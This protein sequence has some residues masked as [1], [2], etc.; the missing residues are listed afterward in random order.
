MNSPVAVFD[1]YESK[2]IRLK[3]RLNYF[4]QRL[5]DPNAQ[6]ILLNVMMSLFQIYKYAPLSDY[7]T[8]I[9]EL[10]ETIDIYFQNLIIIQPIL[11]TTPTP[12]FIILLNNLVNL[13]KQTI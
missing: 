7:F 13:L 1:L 9:P 10:E 8:K 5:T 4:H 11:S 6:K 2:L 3:H 12:N